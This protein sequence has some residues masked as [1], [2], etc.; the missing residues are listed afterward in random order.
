MSTAESGSDI[1][2]PCSPLGRRSSAIPRLAPVH[3]EVSFLIQCVDNMVVCINPTCSFCLMASKFVSRRS[4]HH[5]GQ[6]HIL[7]A[8]IIF[9]QPRILLGVM[10][11]LDTFMIDHLT[12]KIPQV[13]VMRHYLQEVSIE[14]ISLSLLIFLD[15]LFLFVY[16][17]PISDNTCAFLNYRILFR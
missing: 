5:Q 16:L 1:D 17:F 6:L 7:A 2:D 8:M 9:L 4:R 11:G 14:M 3:E 13:F 12:M 10:K 15:T